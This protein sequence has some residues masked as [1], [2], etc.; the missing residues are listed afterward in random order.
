MFKPNRSHATSIT[1]PALSSVSA[2]DYCRYPGVAAAGRLH[3]RAGHGGAGPAWEARAQRGPDGLR[4]GYEPFSIGTGA[5]A[6]LLIH[7]FGSSPSVFARL[8]PTL[9]QRGFTCRVMRLPGFGE[10]LSEY[11]RVTAADWRAAVHAEV[12]ALGPA[13]HQSGLWATHWADCSP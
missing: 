9:A 11:A 13:I 10:P 2:A 5:T 4:R 12:L 6:A 7:G 1:V 3:L 8:A